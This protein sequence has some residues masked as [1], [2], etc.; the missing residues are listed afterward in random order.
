MSIGQRTTKRPSIRILLDNP[1]SV[2]VVRYSRLLSVTL[3]NCCVLI[4]T[5]GVKG[6]LHFPRERFRGLQFSH[7]GI[8][9][10][11]EIPQNVLASAGTG[12]VVSLMSISFTPDGVIPK[13]EALDPPTPFPRPPW[14]PIKGPFEAPPKPEPRPIETP[15][16]PKPEPK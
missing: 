15:P 13:W 2:Y 12:Q 1:D 3:N 14:P 5:S 11:I 16:K 8:I 10:R 6:L 4:T 7:G 9:Q